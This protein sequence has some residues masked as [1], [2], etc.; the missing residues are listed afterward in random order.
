LR[1]PNGTNQ[2]TE[3]V[4]NVNTLGEKVQRPQGNSKAYALQKLSDEG[5]VELLQQVQ[6]GKISADK[7]MKHVHISDVLPCFSY[8]V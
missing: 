6:S 8:M 5:Q 3:G 2:H 4:N 1:R 7:A